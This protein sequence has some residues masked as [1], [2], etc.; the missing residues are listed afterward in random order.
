[1]DNLPWSLDTAFPIEKYMEALPEYDLFP[2]WISNYHYGNVQKH[3]KR[4]FLIGALKSERYTFIPGEENIEQKLCD[5]LLGLEGSTIA[6]HHP[7]AQHVVTG[8]A[9]HLLGR[10][11]PGTWNDMA[12][13]FRASKEGAVMRYT[14]A[15]GEETSRMGLSK[16]YWHKHAHVLT[17]TN[18]MIHPLTGFPLSP[19]ERLRVQG[20]PD[21]FVLYGV[22]IE[23]D[24]TWNHDR[25]TS[26]VKQ[27]GKF[28]PVQFCRYVAKQIAAH[29]NV[30]DVPSCSFKRVL[31]QH[32]CISKAKKAFCDK[33]GYSLREAACHACWLP[34]KKLGCA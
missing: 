12:E 24:G 31:E 34:C 4:F 28:M 18:P 32:P 10:D 33:S 7:H 8:R 23:K 16:G 11:L 13:Y 1:M 30:A 3:R 20:A 29:I 26:I 15:N 21:D 5:H 19:R 25:N 22:K 27:T 2:E 14:K 9:R 6:N 17:G